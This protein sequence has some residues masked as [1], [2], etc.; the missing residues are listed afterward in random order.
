MIDHMT[1][2]AIRFGHGLPLPD[3]APTSPQEMLKAL[4]KPDEAA[5]RFPAATL[6]EALPQRVAVLQ[7]LKIRRKT[8]DKTPFMVAAQ[9]A[10]DVADISVRSGFARALDAPDGFRE[11]LVTFWS[12]HFTTRARTTADVVLP[13]AMIE[14][15]IRP[16]IAGRFGDL[17]VAATLHP[18]MLIYLDQVASVGP[19]SPFGQQRGRGLNENLA[20]EVMELHSLGVGA[21]YAQ[22]DVRQMA[23][24]LTGLGVNARKGLVFLPEQAEPGTETVLGRSY[25]GK[26][27]APIRAALQDLA[28]RPETARHIAW[29]LAV[30]FISDTP[31]EA[32]VAA[33]TR[34]YA[35]SGGAL[36]AVYAAMLDHPTAWVPTLQK[37]RQPYDFMVAALRSLGVNGAGIMRF[38]RRS[39]ARLILRDMALMGQKWRQPSGPDGWA[40]AGDHWITPQGLAS[41]IRWAMEVPGR[42]VTPLP[43]PAE[44]ARRALGSA[45]EVSLIRAAERAE[46][47][48]EGVGFVL[49]SPAFNRR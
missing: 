20:R 1:L 21:G 19:L 2:V 25:Q 38:D 42:L 31:D 33:M 30:H 29:K 47:L 27:V 37:V 18:A 16:N 11:R 12:D 35:D 8:G 39:F 43:D 6:K 41:R 23:E 45:A 36:L 32:L 15:A 9:D 22:D 7:G 4:S 24:L 40:E 48:R 14:D 49:A 17:L 13:G 26:G 46:S 10:R 3:G 28:L 5:R 34:A 44:M